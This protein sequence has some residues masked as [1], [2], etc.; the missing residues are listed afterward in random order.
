MPNS[1]DLTATREPES[2]KSWWDLSEKVALV[3]GATGW[4]GPEIA[5]A[6]ANLGATV[7]VTSRNSKKLALLSEK[8]NEQ[9]LAS[10]SIACDLN[11]K[12]DVDSLIDNISTNQKRLDIL[13]NNAHGLPQV[14]DG[15]S[16]EILPFGLLSNLEAF[17]NLTS[18]SIP[19]LKTTASKFRDASII[20]IASMY[21]KVSPYPHIYEQTQ[22]EPNPIFY[23]AT[24]ASIIQMTKWLACNLGKFSIRV[25][26]ISPGAFP[27]DEVQSTNPDFVN[28]LA[29]QCPLGRIG[30]REEIA[31]AV[32]FLAGSGSTYITG[33]DVSV[34]GGWTAW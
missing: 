18:S 21:G 9:G 31:G 28:A 15:E 26:S 30:K 5:Y 24:K 25:N 12:E 33:S 29:R 13:V 10:V 17:W 27:N 20:N 19:L 32:S 22:A 3:S 11:N 4:F 1:Q 8:L 16:P 7:F 14:T 2:Q 23:G 34:D 6:L